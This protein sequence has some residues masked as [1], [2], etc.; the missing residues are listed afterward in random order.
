M[1]FASFNVENLF[2]R[3]RALNLDTWEEGEPVL[4]AFAEFNSLIEHVVYSPEDKARMIELLV[5]LDVYRK[6]SG[7]VLR[8]RTPTPQWAWLRANRGAFDVEHDDTGIEIVADS[9]AAWTGW[10][11][12]AVEP[13][14]EVNTRMTAQVIHDVN[15]DVQGVVEAEDRPSLDRFNQDLLGGQFSHVMLIDGNDTRGIDVGI[16]TPGQVDIVSMHS[17]VDEPDPGAT[18]EHLFSR[19]CIEYLCRLPSGATVRVLLN[20]FKSQSGGGGPKRSRQAQGVRKIVDE[21][22]AAGETNLI[23]MGDLNEGPDGQGNSAT[24]FAPLYGPNSPLVDVY[25]LAAF[26]TGPKPGTFQTCS[27]TN[28]LDYIFVSKNLAPLVVGGGIERHGL[29]GGP[30]NVNPPKAWAIYPDIKGPEHAASDHAAVFV[31]INI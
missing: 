30:K 27:I 17:N 25:S 8:N 11:E 15:A 5:Q 7:V 3:P 31:D 6:T 21:L 12:L 19:D 13:V 18:G 4:K 1:R 28:R 9:R 20:H 23:V 2:A 22:L 29:W 24:N 14:D 26:N 10:L 16:M